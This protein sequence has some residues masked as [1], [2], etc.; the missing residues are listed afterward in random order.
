MTPEDDNQ[1]TPVPHGVPLDGAQVL[2]AVGDACYVLDPEWRFVFLNARAERLLRRSRAELLGTRV[3]DEFPEA[4][5]SAFERQYRRA[6][7]GGVPVTVEEFYPPLDTWF[8]VRAFPFSGGVAVFFQDIDARK[9]AEG[10]ARERTTVILESITD[11]FYALDAD[12]RFT[13]VNRQAEALWGRPREEFLGRPLLDVFPQMAGSASLSRHERAGAAREPTHFETLSPII[14]RWVEVSVYPVASGGM[15]VFFRDISGRKALEK[16]RERLAEDNRLL[17]ESTGD[18]LYGIDLE[19]CFTF[20]NRTAEKMLGLTREQALGRNAHALIHHTRPDGTPY[21]EEECPIYHAL[22]ETE[23]VRVEDDVF[24]RADGTAFAVSFSAAP[25]FQEGA[26]RGAVVTF[27]DIGERKAL[28]AERE[29]QLAR[30]H[31]RAEREAL[32]NRI[33]QAMRAT[34]DP[35]AVQGA[36][37]ALLGEA[38]GA[39]RCYFSRYDLADDAL[40]IG[41]D[42]IA[43]DYRRGG[44]PPLAGLYRLSDFQVNP[45]DYYAGGRTLVMEDALTPSW[46]FPNVLRDA[47][48]R[49]RVRAALAVPLFEEGRLVATLTAAMADEPRAWTG[50]EVA[51]VE[52]V[53]AQTRSAVEAA[54]LLAAEQDRLQQEALA[55]RIGAALRSEL[56][57]DAIQGRAAELLGE[58]LGVNRCF[59]LT[60]DVAGDA[61]T[62]G[63]DFHRPDLPSLEGGYRLSDFQALLAEVFAGGGTAAIADVRAAL[64]RNASAQMEAFAHRAMLAVPFFDGGK[65]VAALWASCDAPRAWTGQEAVLM[66]QT[67]TMTRTALEAMRVRAQEH[68][69]AQQLQEALQPAV[70]AHVPGLSLGHHSQPALDE[71]QVGGDFYDVF[72]LDK[73]LYAMVLGDVSGKGLAAAQQ[74][75]LIRNSLRTTLY[76]SRAPARAAAALNGIVTSHDLLVGFVTCWVGIYDVSTGQV[77]YCSCGHE[78]AL[79]R[80]T[81]GE[82]EALETT[83]PPLGVSENAE[84][85]ELSVTLSSGDALVLYTDGISEAGPSRREMLGTE[86][87]ARLLTVLPTGMGTQA[88]AETLVEQVRAFAG[89]FRDDVAVLLARRE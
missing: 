74:L 16:E 6:V 58:A 7:A 85:G 67:A 43:E 54:L 4:M 1:P 2:E 73:G 53:A 62:V 51:L 45:E 17:L 52:A 71:A 72:P 41:T 13:H 69:I 27:S 33:G 63:H 77:A 35:E 5:G 78:P 84:Y 11:A 80:R 31:A 86:G 40:W 50:D 79:V 64:S 81:G 59:Y 37:V 21:P 82:V 22:R 32:L 68:R 83:G 89:A 60:Y 23:G 9:R 75:A 36:A 12:W 34:T 66:E 28:E 39:D 20:L 48:Q 25:I 19:G 88:Q 46:G 76:L 8:E 44:L 56:D 29:R 61:A 57:P 10:E 87:L 38:L 18:G 55:G 14:G 42:F 26:A 49:L 30:E 65:L 3:W 70:P 15:S 24:W 47:L